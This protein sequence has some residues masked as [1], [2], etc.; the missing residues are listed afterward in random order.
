M[1]LL[2]EFT[3]LDD[4]GRSRVMRDRVISAQ[5]PFKSPFQISLLI[6]YF[7]PG[8]FPP[9]VPYLSYPILSMI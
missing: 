2:R 8:G 5:M 4:I 7:R 6:F 1:P 3:R 9:R